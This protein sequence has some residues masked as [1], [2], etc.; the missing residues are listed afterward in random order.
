MCTSQL[1]GYFILK[2]QN[3]YVTQ[4]I[5]SGRMRWAVHVPGMAEGRTACRVLVVKPKFKRPLI[6]PRRRW[7]INT[8][9]QAVNV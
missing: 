2:Q 5:K 6:R 9:R 7:K 8:T 4:S 3:L 1:Y